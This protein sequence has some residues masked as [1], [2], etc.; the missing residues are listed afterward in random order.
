M[1]NGMTQEDKDLLLKDLCGRLP[2]KVMAQYYDSEDE[3][4]TLDEIEGIESSGHV[5]I[6]QYVL[7]IENI[8]PYLFP[9]SSITEEQAKEMQEIVGSPKV[10]CIMR[11]TGGLELWL[12]SIDTDP[13]IWLDTIFE[14]QDWLNKNHFDYRGLIPKSLALDATGLNIY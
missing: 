11:K 14:V 7:P 12:D 6:G 8:R 1:E 10:A 13:T 5:E 4:E 2:Y 9:L 3:C